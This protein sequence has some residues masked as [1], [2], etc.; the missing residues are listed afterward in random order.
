[1]ARHECAIDV[2]GLVVRRGRRTVLDG[3][4]CQVTTGSVTG[5]L[6][7]SGSGKTTL[8]RAVVGVQV[9]AG[10][11]VT[12]LG[13][14][15]GAVALRSR[16][17]YVTQSPSVYPDLTV[18]EN[19]RDFAALAGAGPQAAALAVEEVG[20]TPASR[21]LVGA[22]S[23]GQRSRASLACAFVGRPELLVL[24][25]PTVGL[26]PLLREE[27]WAV[28]RGRAQAGAPCWSPRTSWTRR[29]AAIVCC[30][31]GTVP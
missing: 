18:L 26:D 27:L 7:P 2:Q 22:L 25:E 16:I 21:Q 28:I 3:L 15:A 5:L 14:P 17:G 8:L 29:P 19:A 11:T 9:V 20:L 1:M 23:G 30:S 31:C 6:G 12:V 4:S 10:G 24:D 13:R